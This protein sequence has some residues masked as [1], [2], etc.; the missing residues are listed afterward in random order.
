MDLMVVM[1]I[2]A[3]MVIIVAIFIIKAMMCTGDD[4]I[5][6]YDLI[7]P[8]QTFLKYDAASNAS[9]RVLKSEQVWKCEQDLILPKKKSVKP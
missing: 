7:C 1:T 2:I 9:K 8:T 5:I 3:V 4:S 6:I